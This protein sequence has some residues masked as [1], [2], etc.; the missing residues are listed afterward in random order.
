M[1]G[2]HAIVCS[3]LPNFCTTSP[4]HF[5]SVHVIAIGFVYLIGSVNIVNLITLALHN[6]QNTV[7]RRKTKKKKCLQQYRTKSCTSKISR[8]KDKY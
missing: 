1:T 8:P 2:F 6:L 7:D 3:F 5:G 4:T